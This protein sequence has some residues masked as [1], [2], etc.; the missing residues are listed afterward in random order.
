MKKISLLLTVALSASMLNAQQ[1]CG[2]HTNHIHQEATNPQY[3]AERARIEQETQNYCSHPLVKT[4]SSITIPVVV[5]VVYNTSVQNISDAQIQSQMDVLNEDFRLL[6]ANFTNTP[7]VFQPL[8]AD[9]E[10]NFVLAQQDPMGI[11]TNGIVRVSTATTTFTTNDAVKFSSTGGSDAWDRN[12]YLNIWICKL[13][14][15]VLGYAQ[16]PGG[17]AATD[18]VVVNYNTFGTVGTLSYTYNK[19]R[20]AVH[21]IG[22]WLNLYHI[23]GD[24]NGACFGSDQV[25]DTPNQGDENYGNPTFPQVSCNNGPNG[26]MFMNFMDY[27]N[28]AALTMFTMGQKQRMHALFAPNGFRYPLL[29]SNGGTPPPCNTPA[30]LDVTNLTTTDATLV[31]NTVPG[32]LSYN[33]N[34]QLLGASYWNTL[35]IS[36]TECVISNPAIGSSYRFMVQTV[37]PNGTSNFSNE[38]YFTLPTN[39]NT[40]SDPWEGN[41]SFATATTIAPTAQLKG[42]VGQPYDRDYFTFTTTANEPKF[43][44]ELTDLP[45]DYDLR[46]YNASM[47][48]LQKSTKIGTVNESIKYNPTAAGTYFVMVSGFQSV[49]HPTNC[50]QFGMVT[51]ANDFARLEGTPSE[52]LERAVYPNPATDKLYIPVFGR[53][54]K[55][56]VSIRCTALTGQ[57]VREI[58]VTLSAGDQDVVLDIQTLPMGMYMLEVITEE[59]KQSFRFLKE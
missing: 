14:G 33:V 40:C 11:P 41:N 53:E 7:G 10:I 31:W 38:Y 34:Y 42:L 35:N 9:C 23:W 3:A 55:N 2:T 50:Y 18:G 57:R 12:R 15:G 54:E 28:D 6:N 1:Q 30:G 13:S 21:E 16:Y 46:L 49:H 44:I 43:K 4:R 51:S 26:D 47:T 29:S 27:A 5:H 39:I 48:L 37:C 58:T 22:H 59:E 8:A 52:E 25:N 19:G 24:D 36:D 45:A 17:A 32:A 20:T 56:T